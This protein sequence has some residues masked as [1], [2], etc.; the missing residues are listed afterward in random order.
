MKYQVT[1]SQYFDDYL[2][3]TIPFGQ[4][5]NT[6]QEAESIKKEARSRYK[7]RPLVYYDIKI[8]ESE[9]QS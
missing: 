9:E 5:V 3:W 8:I 4:T 2:E 6:K 1:V 7:V